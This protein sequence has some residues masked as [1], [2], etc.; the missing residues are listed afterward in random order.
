[1][2]Q[3]KSLVDLLQCQIVSYVLINLDF[4]QT[5]HHVAS[6]IHNLSTTYQLTVKVGYNLPYSY[7]C[8]QAEALVNGS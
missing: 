3:I 1:M 4:L 8:Q 5:N 6:S 2:Q 7:T